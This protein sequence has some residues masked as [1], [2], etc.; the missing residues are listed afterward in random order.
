MIF[1]TVQRKPQM[2]KIRFSVF[3]KM[4]KFLKSSNILIPNRCKYRHFFLDFQKKCLLFFNFFAA[5]NRSIFIRQS[6]ITYETSA[7]GLLLYPYID[8]ELY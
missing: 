1:F 5:Y 8:Y 4:W 3:K 7:R 2:Q 6:D